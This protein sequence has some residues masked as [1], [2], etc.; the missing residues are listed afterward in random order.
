MSGSYGG[1][2]TAR[3]PPW[4][5]AGIP[6]IA[7]FLVGGIFRPRTH[8]KFVQ[9]GLAKDDGSGIAQTFDRKG[10][11]KGSEAFKDTRA[12]RGRHILGAKGVLDRNRHTPKWFCRVWPSRVQLP[13]LLKGCLASHMEQGSNGRFGGLNTSKTGLYG[14]FCADFPVLQGTTERGQ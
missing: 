1:R 11:V 6:R 12:S 13:G 7:G 9:I 5:L 4:H 2:R 14:L 8:G 10:I 3:A